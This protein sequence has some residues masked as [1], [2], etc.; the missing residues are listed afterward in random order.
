MILPASQS[1]AE[2]TWL[3]KYVMVHNK[4]GSQKILLYSN[5]VKNSGIQRINIHFLLSDSPVAG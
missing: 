1:C 2:Y 3:P 4:Q 5:L